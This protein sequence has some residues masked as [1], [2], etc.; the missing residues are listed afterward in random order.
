MPGGKHRGRRKGVEVRPGSVRKARLEAGLT[1]AEVGGA[2]VSRTAIY[3]IETGRTRPTIE[4]LEQIA[5]KTNR[6]VDFFVAET[7]TSAVSGQYDD[8]LRE[9]ERL[10]LVR[11]FQSAIQT[12]SALLEKPLSHEAA[13]FAHFYVGQAYCRL[14]TPAGAIEHLT[15]AREWFEL[16][17]DRWMAVEILDWESSALGL[18]QDPRALL[19]AQEA[20]DRCRRLEPTPT[21]I[22]VRILGHIAGMCVAAHSWTQAVRYYEAAAQ[23]AGSVKDLLQLAKMHHGLGIAYQGL[24]QPIAARR[25]FDKALA[26]YSVE[27]D[28]SD[29]YRVENDLGD[30]LLSQGQLESAEQH[31]R[32]ALDGTTEL[33]IDPQSRGYILA[34]LG[35]VYL[36]QGRLP[37]A[38]QHAAE[39]LSAG[40]MVGERIVM[41]NAHALLGQLDARRGDPRSADEHFERAIEILEQ[42]QMLDRLR[43]CHMEYADMLYERNEIA[44]AA[45]H[46]KA[47]AEVARA[48]A[49]GLNLD[50]ATSQ[51]GT[52]RQAS[53]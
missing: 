20:L 15:Q 52:Q 4:T 26:L 34:N 24:Q 17:G 18:M 13:A 23:A 36:R 44:S 5:A 43:D 27:S 12:G 41:A 47:A 19:L 3:L 2:L 42:L 30:L 28:L 7:D 37:E 45:L 9:L 33:H 39:A 50:N 11:D 14:A 49:L 1:L 48:S 10:I 38:Q 6:P 32:A 53:R 29:V 16:A 25:H 31:F 8:D 22:E 51:S 40:A 21:N 35:H 46:W